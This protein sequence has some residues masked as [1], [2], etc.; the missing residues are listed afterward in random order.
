MPTLVVNTKEIIKSGELLRV[1]VEDSAGKRI[2]ES[3]I[4]ADTIQGG[5]QQETANNFGDWL[6]AQDGKDFD[7]QTALS[8][9]ELTINWDWADADDGTGGTV[10]VR[11]RIGDVA[12]GPIP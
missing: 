2:I 9:K 7:R 10:P 1:I 4:R 3:E 11:Q 12:V 5:S 6:L 8:D